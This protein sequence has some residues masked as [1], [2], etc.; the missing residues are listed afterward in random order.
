MIYV[1]RGDRGPMVA[2]I[3]N[4]INLARGGNVLT[5]DGSYGQLTHEAINQFQFNAR[6]PMSGM[7]TRITW[8]RLAAS[9]RLS[10]FALN[11]IYDPRR[12]PV[13][14][15]EFRRPG[16]IATGGMSGG[17]GQVISDVVAQVR[18][19]GRIALLRFN[20]HGRSGLQ[21][22]TAG[23]GKLRNSLGEVIPDLPPV[24]HEY[25][26][27]IIAITNFRMI[28]PHL[29]LLRSHFAPFASI[30]FHGC[31][32]GRGADGAR[33]LQWTADATGVPVSAGTPTQSYGESTAYRFEGPV[34][35]VY[36]GRATLQQWIQS[37]LNLQQCSHPVPASAPICA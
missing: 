13:T 9:Q 18:A 25:H 2:A 36:P 30:E 8:D 20:G 1:R 29:M 16:L 10:L 33:L 28:E 31:K 15:P 37:Q 3:Q 17:V 22:V 27:S 35:T 34:R 23:C 5:V 32:V 11:D 14:P 12:D 6:L 24:D 21:A 7:V 19:L 4:L 26:Q